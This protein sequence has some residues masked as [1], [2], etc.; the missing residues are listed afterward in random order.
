MWPQFYMIA[1]TKQVTKLVFYYLFGLGFYRTMYVFNW[2]YRYIA[3]NHYDPISTYSGIVQIV[4]FYIFF[5]FCI[6]K[7]KLFLLY[8][9]TKLIVF[10]GV[11]I[12][13]ENIISSYYDKNIVESKNIILFTIRLVFYLISH[14]F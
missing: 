3:Q 4:P 10:I 9:K 7:S 2:V 11:T 5:L 1:K 12:K 14:I 13:Q 6:T 8:I